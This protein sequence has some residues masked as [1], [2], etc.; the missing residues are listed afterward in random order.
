[1]ADNGRP[2]PHSKTRLNDQGIKT[3]FIIHYPN[4]IKNNSIS[5]SLISSI[6]IAPTILDLANIEISESFQGKSFV[7]IIEKPDLKFRNY[8]F[9]EHNW[10]DYESYQRMVRND[11]YLYIRNSRTQFPQEGPLDAI[12]SPTYIDLK[13]AEK[14]NSISL[15]QAEIFISPRP[16]EELYDM[17]NDPYQFNNLLLNDNIPDDFKILQN[18][19]DK[20]ILDT[21]DTLP[22]NITK[23]WYLREQEP[24]NQSSLL[25]T[26]YHGIRGE[27]PGASSNAVKINNKGPF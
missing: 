20:W 1:M 23:D 3:P 27:M 19:L 8:V 16:H 11:N 4:I 10:H 13:N 24:F 5:K 17:N 2:F 6:D 18:I 26:E 7:E 22:E 9:A 21:G 14:N 12:N 25:K 15:K